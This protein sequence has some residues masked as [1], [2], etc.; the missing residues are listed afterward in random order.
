MSAE[1]VAKSMGHHAH[2][3]FSSGFDFVDALIKSYEGKATTE[4]INILLIQPGDI[5]HILYTISRRRRHIEKFG[6][7]LPKINFYIL[8]TQVETVT[9]D[10]LLLQ[11]LTD[12]EVPIRQRANIYLE[13]FGNNKVQRRTSEYIDTLG[14]QLKVLSAK[15][16]G[17]L[18][19][20]IDFS[21]LNYRERDLFET[22]LQAYATSFP[23][24]MDSLY[25]HRQRGLY[26]D[27]YDSR[28]ALSDWDY[29]AGIKNKASIVHIK[30]YRQWR[31]N[32]I[33]FE[34]GDQTY[35]EPNRTLMTFTEGFMK[36]GKEKGLKKEVRRKTPH[37]FP[38][39]QCTFSSNPTTMSLEFVCFTCVAS[40]Y[41]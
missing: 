2:W 37:L 9:R 8:E 41:R 25:D 31:Q 28:K 38:P 24:D 21:M 14:K 18:D 35:S 15:G 17:T 33:A 13:V 3:G 40:C 23:F 34:F 39:E 29:H 20:V 19:H 12:Y 36:K 11:I 16:T 4:T 6:G 5:R 1:S 26:E 30:Q 27:R 22:A 32:G 7:T 10:L